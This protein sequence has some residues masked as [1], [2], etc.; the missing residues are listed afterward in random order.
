[1]IKM[2]KRKTFVLI[3]LLL[4]I[5]L[6]GCMSETEQYIQGYWYRGNAHFMDQWQ[7][8]RGSFSHISEVVQGDPNT[9]SGHYQVVDLQDDRLTLELYD[10]DLTFGDERQQI[11]ITLHPDS[12]TVQIRSQIF[13]RILP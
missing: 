9:T 1:M 2:H 5:F 6:A 13:D 3:A 11:V 10:L 8:D 4:I 12:D 7:F